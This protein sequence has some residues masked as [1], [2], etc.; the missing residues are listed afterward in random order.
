MQGSYPISSLD[1]GSRVAVYPVPS[2]EVRRRARCRVGSTNFAEN[3]KWR[4]KRA[5]RAAG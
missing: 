1:A 2:L 3:P 5:W 4:T